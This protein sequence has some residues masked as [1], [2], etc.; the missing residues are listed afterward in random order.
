MGNS[1][2][3]LNEVRLQKNSA[4]TK[5]LGVNPASHEAVA[6]CFRKVASI[7]LPPGDTGSRL[8]VPPRTQRAGRGDAGDGG[9]AGD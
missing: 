6:H 4:A 2:G 8:P 5:R 3:R 7:F 1:S 9:P